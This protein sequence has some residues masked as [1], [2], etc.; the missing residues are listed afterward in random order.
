MHTMNRRICIYASIVALILTATVATTHAQNRPRASLTDPDG[1]ALFEAACATCH[2]SDGRGR[3]QAEVGFP[4]PL[5]DFTDCDF[6]AREPNADWSAIIHEGG[7]VRGFN[8]MMPAFGAALTEEQ[9]EAALTR[10]RS[11]CTNPDWPRGELNLPRA[12]FTEK[13]YPEDEAVITTT[14]NTEGNSSIGTKFL[15]EQRFGTRNQMELSLPLYRA[16]L[17]D[18]LGWESGA[19]D[20][21]IAY[22]RAMRHSLE[23]GSIFTLGAELVLPTGDEARGFGSG[24]TVLEPY[25]AYGKL[26]GRMQ[27]S[28]VQLQA[29]TELP[30]DRSRSD[31]GQV[32]VA[33]GRTMTSGGP[34]GRAWTPMLEVLAARELESGADT[35]YDVVP[36]FQ[37]TLSKRQHV[38][39]NAGF[40]V[41]VNNTSGRDTQFIFYL[42]WDWFDGGPLEGW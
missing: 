1:V 42:L 36:Q 5:P 31:E 14:V 18:P 20:L 40:R 35:N 21:A 24:T 16:D 30:A 3:S 15:Y 34:F 29:L 39:A 28:F 17:G 13:A 26:L 2:G 6:A 8:R 11:F 4:T 32:R 38:I 7:P 41:P 10:L 22:K 9:I 25:L 12:L 23:R 19:G 37:V 33:F 27:A